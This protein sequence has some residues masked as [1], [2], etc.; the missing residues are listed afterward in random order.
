MKQ[1]IVGAV[2]TAFDLIGGKLSSIS[3]VNIGIETASYLLNKYKLNSKQFKFLVLGQVGQTPL[4]SNIARIIGS[5]LNNNSPA[6]TVHSNCTSSLEALKTVLDRMK[7][8]DIPIALAGGLESMSQMYFLA[9]INRKDKRFRTSEKIKDNWSDAKNELELLD[10]L[11]KGLTCGITGL[12]MLEITEIIGNNYKVT[13]EEQTDFVY[14]SYSRASK[15]YKNQENYL[16]KINDLQY[17]ELPQQYENKDKNYFARSP[18]ILKKENLENNSNFMQYIH[19]KKDFSPKVSRHG[20]CSN[21]DGAG[22][23][24]IMSEEKA[25]QLGYYIQGEVV[26]IDV[27]A[28]DPAVALMAPGYSIPKLLDKNQINFDDVYMDIH[29]PFANSALGYFKMA[30]RK[31]NQNWIKKFYDSNINRMGDSLSYSHPL[32]ATNIRNVIN[33]L[34]VLN[35]DKTHKYAVASGCAAGGIAHSVLIKKYDN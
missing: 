22:F 27:T 16:L 32:A 14:E 17:D 18:I 2:R 31:Y 23:L 30:Q 33:C 4:Y 11:A 28:I 24:L 12:N 25:K 20:T 1:V 3:P 7:N 6:T 5:K 29:I 34:K 26:D 21:G 10:L 8:D 13:Q 19:D 35:E 9:N 15:S